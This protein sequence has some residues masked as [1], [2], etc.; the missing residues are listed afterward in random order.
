MG[1][2][3]HKFAIIVLS[4]FVLASGG[5]I[6]YKYYQE[7]KSEAV[8]KTQQKVEK[9]CFTRRDWHCRNKGH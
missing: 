9:E 1:I 2:R 5:I 3:K 8:S 6:G 4:G 7:E